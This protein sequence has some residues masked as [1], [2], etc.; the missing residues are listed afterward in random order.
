MSA[1]TTPSQLLGRSHF[2]P[3]PVVLVVVEDLVVV[4]VGGAVLVVGEVVSFEVVLMS[5]FLVVLI[6]SGEGG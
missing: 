4:G 1:A 6:G 5:G 3:S 2:F